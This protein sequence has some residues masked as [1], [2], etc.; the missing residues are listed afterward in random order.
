MIQA[1]TFDVFGTV[2]DWRTSILEE[3][4]ALSATTGLVVDWSGLA[5]AWRAG[6]QPAMQQVRSGALPWTSIDALHRRILDELAP[7]FG[8]TA[9]HEPELAHFNRVWHRLQPWP[10][11][12]TGLERLRRR[13]LVATLSNGNMALLANLAKH[14]DLRWDLILSAELARH[15]KPD[16]QV[17]QTALALLDLAPDQVMMVAAHVEDLRA[18]RDQGMHTAYVHRPLEY[19]PLRTVELPPDGEF[20][21]IATDFLD[22]AHQLD[23]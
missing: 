22:L 16:P 18:A 20:D 4:Q 6:Y 2:V 3:G 9:L 13:Y 15:Y 11:A 14:A 1:L 7:R 12:R 19:G 8:L 10:D 23:A 17:Y 21:V 5:E